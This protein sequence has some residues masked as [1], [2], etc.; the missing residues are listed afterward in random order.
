MLVDKKLRIIL[1]SFILLIGF[2][3][4]FVNY[5]IWPREGATF[6]EFAWPW[7]GISLIKDKIP[8]SWSPHSQ[9]KNYKILIFRKAPFRI[10]WPY[11][12]H[13]PLFGLLSGSFALLTG[14]KNMYDADYV[15][16][17]N[18]RK[19]SLF[20]GTVSI[21]FIYLLVSKLYDYKMGFLS[22]LLY[23]TIP[24]IA[25]GSRLLQNENFMIPV[26][27]LTLYLLSNYLETGKKKLLWVVALISAVALWAKIPWLVIGTSV[28][29]ILI[30]KRRWKDCFPVSSLIFL[31]L[32]LFLLYGYYWNWE[33]FINLWRLQLT[34]YEIGLEGILALFTLPHLTDR[35]LVDGWIYFGWLAVFMI[36]RDFK[37][38]FFIIIPFLTYFLF[39]VWAVPGGAAQGWYKYPFYPFLII[40]ISYAIIEMIRSPSF[41]ALVFQFM[42]GSSGFKLGYEPLF[43]IE[44]FLFRSLILL[45]SLPILVYF[46]LG[47]KFKKLY[48]RSF[49]FWLAV[50]L[51][52][53]I[54]ATRLYNEQ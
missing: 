14:A 31:S 9:Y 8:M 33:L 48:Q 3:A 5:S 16:P 34:R 17:Q 15:N 26:W 47:D 24:S 35:F 43:G 1:L 19:L 7:L 44:T 13:P 53:N 46:F 37:K 50:F 54:S 49:V 2:Y 4:R 22:S 18:L 25:V 28:C 42:V 6:D 10:V 23:A 38:H 11:L 30:Y 21:L 45:W 12:E 36:L 39:Y 51:L 41:L 32:G 52:L 40:A 27:L 29:G 20:L